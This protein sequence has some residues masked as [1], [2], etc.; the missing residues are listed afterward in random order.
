L[1]VWKRTYYEQRIKYYIFVH[2]SQYEFHEY[3]FLVMNEA[4]PMYC[5]K[6]TW[7]RFMEGEDFRNQSDERNAEG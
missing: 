7:R 5:I 2:A 6:D 3:I 4:L 1:Q